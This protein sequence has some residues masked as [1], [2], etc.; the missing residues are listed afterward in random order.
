MVAGG[1]LDFLLKTPS[2]LRASQITGLMVSYSLHGRKNP[3]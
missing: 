2:T 1:A 3:L